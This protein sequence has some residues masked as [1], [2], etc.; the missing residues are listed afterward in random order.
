MKDVLDYRS[1]IPLGNLVACAE[2]IGQA[3]RTPKKPFCPPKRSR[4]QL[5]MRGNICLRQ[6][7]IHG[8]MQW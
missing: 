7:E 3:G 4:K 6:I 1:V 2:N 5:R 8:R